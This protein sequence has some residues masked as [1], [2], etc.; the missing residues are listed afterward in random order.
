MRI[1]AGSRRGR[2]L[3]TLTGTDVR[4]TGDRVREA[5]FNALGSMG[6]IEDANVLDLFAGSG[7]LG[8]EAI[9][10]GAKHVTF[11]DSSPQALDV[12][13]ANIAACDCADSCTVVRSE[14]AAHLARNQTTYDLVLL[15]PPYEFDSWAEL[16][17]GLEAQTLVIE[18]NR[19]IEAPAGSQV[20]RERKYG[21]TVVTV[22]A[23]I[24]AVA[25]DRPPSEEHS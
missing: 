23:P 19:P 9:S 17:S 5:I 20:L 14:A 6:V 18:S 2:K 7:A 24:L 1:V 8:L 4:P 12:V 21:G 11:V 16:L 3:T 25:S 15:D 13:R 22:M 10:R